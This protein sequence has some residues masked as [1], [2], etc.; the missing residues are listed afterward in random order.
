MRL[1][2]IV[3]IVLSG[4]CTLR[5]EIVLRQEPP[6]GYVTCWKWATPQNAL[7][8]LDQGWSPWADPATGQIDRVYRAMKECEG[9]DED[10]APVE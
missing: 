3:G 6:K 10:A 8:L 2:L 9:H 1:A 5:H 4:A 7:E